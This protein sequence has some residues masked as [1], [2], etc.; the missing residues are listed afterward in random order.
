MK[1]MTYRVGHH[2]TS[3]DSTKYRPIDEIEHWK[4]IHSPITRFRKWIE[5]KGWWSE[6]QE[7]DLQTDLNNQVIVMIVGLIHFTKY[8]LIYRMPKIS[9][10]V[11]KLLYMTYITKLNT[12]ASYIKV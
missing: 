5:R 1:A 3:D 2:S 11:N 9:K 7:L 12:Y 8:N 10:C 4:T 6:E